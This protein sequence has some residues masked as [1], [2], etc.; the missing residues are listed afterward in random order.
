MTQ[1]AKVAVFPSSEVEPAA[2]SRQRWIVLALLATVVLL[3]QTT[4]W[5]AWRHVTDATINS[6]GDFLVG[7]VVGSWYADPATGAI[8]DLLGMGFLS[9]AALVLVRRRRSA[10]V[11][12]PAALMISG[13]G[14][15]LL[16]RLGT[17][18]WTAPGS[19]RGAVDFIPLN[20]IYYN[21]A[22]VVITVATLL[23]VLSTGYLC[24]RLPYRAL[25]RA[26][27]PV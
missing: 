13:W 14:S 26:T 17:H 11:L 6:G 23:F 12:V 20:R 16:D 7:P 3:D 2:G 22:D 25:E 27:S 15:N 24:W 9:V 8:L 19:A 5:W 18:S 4:K 10:A 1:D 21:L